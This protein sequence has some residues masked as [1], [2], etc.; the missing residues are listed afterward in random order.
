MNPV[1]LKTLAVK[2]VMPRG[3]NGVKE[4][5]YWVNATGLKSKIQLCVKEP[6]PSCPGLVPKLK[7]APGMALKEPVNVLFVKAK[8]KGAAWA[9]AAASASTEAANPV[10]RRLRV[11]ISN[12]LCQLLGRAERHSKI[13]HCTT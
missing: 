9:G 7:S 5:V 6:R 3:E 4:I 1:V 11:F 2:P 10:A 8:P 13:F 12:S